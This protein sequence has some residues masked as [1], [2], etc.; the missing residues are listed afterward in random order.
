[1][2]KLLFYILACLLIFE[3]YGQNTEFKQYPSGL[4]YSDTTMK[5]L[6]AIIDSLHI[7]FKSCELNKTYYAF[8]QAKVHFVKLDKGNVLAA[9]QDM[10]NG[11]DF[12]DFVKKYPEAIVERDLLVTRFYDKDYD[13]KKLI[14]INSL[15]EERRITVEASA[16]QEARLVAGQWVID[17]WEK[18]K[19]TA[20]SIRAFFLTTNF[21]T[22]PLPDS[23]ARMVLY[24]ECMVD[25]T[26]SIF[27]EGAYR[28]GVRHET[29]SG[30]KVLK[31][32]NYVNRATKKP[33]YDEKDYMAYAQKLQHWD[34]IK[35]PLVDNLLS[36]RV[37]FADLLS[38]AVAE[39]LVQGGS[40]D[41]F[42]WYVGRYYSRK[43]ELELKRGRIVVG[44]CSM[45]N[46]P[47]MH[48]F[49][50]AVLS[51]ETVNWETFL[52]AHLDIMNDHFARVTDGSYA[53]AQ[54]QTYIQELEVL[55]IQVLDLL[56]G[57]S[58]RIENPSQHHYFGNIPRI[59]RALSETKFA[60]EIEAKMLE[61]I[62]N[63]ALDDYNR[64]VIYYLFDNYNHYITDD[65]KKKENAQ[66]LAAAVKEL[67]VY[68]AKRLN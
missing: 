34:S 30:S 1:M 27:K 22:R 9:K 19:Y 28:S 57:I 21:E 38:A 64:M 8:N 37:E 48:A 35:T 67:P 11:M 55:D 36:K 25:T 10:E 50:I 61:M 58:L 41:E 45:D 31:F 7:K 14:E 43:S 3:A 47:R 51:A 26:A 68:L 63:P 33:E 16:A 56:L 5:Q 65:A 42:E 15:I 12:E 6:A 44:G 39:A 18:S 59:G 53:W 24:S 20:E 2:K 23:Y 49:Q 60:P 66:K 46:S 32:M 54:R 62:R 17:Y 29:K 52:R 13:G 4:M 40:S